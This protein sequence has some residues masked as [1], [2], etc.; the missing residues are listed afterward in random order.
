MSQYINFFI[1]CDKT[2]VPLFSFSRNSYIYGAFRG[3]PY[4]KVT[5]LTENTLA[6]VQESLM[7]EMNTYKARLKQNE[8]EK[9]VIPVFQNSVDEKLESIREINESI[10]G[11]Q[12]ELG[13]LEMGLN[14][15]IVMQ[16]ILET[17]KYAK[18]D[19][20]IEN[21]GENSVIYYG[22]EISRPSLEDI[23]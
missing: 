18:D 19:V 20:N 11:I 7:S 6:N 21:Y 15:C 16:N 23:V 14:Y 10:G 8:A 22:I 9:K 1:R 12:E 17:A 2:F 4:E 3:A 13:D 5:A